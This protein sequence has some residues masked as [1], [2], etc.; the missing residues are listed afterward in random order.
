MPR[1]PRKVAPSSPQE[2]ARLPARIDAE[3]ARLLAAQMGLISVED[4]A[5][6][7][8]VSTKAIRNRPTSVLPP[9]VKLG[10]ALYYRREEYIRL[11]GL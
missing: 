7:E 3:R 8:Q 4:L 5:A 1:T 10:R 6:L 11:R 2:I 9:R